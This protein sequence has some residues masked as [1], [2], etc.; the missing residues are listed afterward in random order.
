MNILSCPHCHGDIKIDIIMAPDS[1]EELRVAALK[2]WRSTLSPQDLEILDAAERFGVIHAF[3]EAWRGG[4]NSVPNI[5]QKAFWEF[6]GRMQPIHLEEAD[7]R[8]VKIALHSRYPAKRVDVY[9]WNAV[10]ALMVNGILEAFIPR[11]K[12]LRNQLEAGKS[13]M[14]VQELTEAMRPFDEWMRTGSGYVP[15]DARTFFSEV[16]KRH[17]GQFATLGNF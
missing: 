15:A 11:S 14:R 6:L 7:W 5:T 13:V 17:P 10:A 9:A 2:R 4:Q 8:P 3:L 1:P 16:N 12:L